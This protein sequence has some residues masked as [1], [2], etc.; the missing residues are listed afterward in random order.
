MLKIK[1]SHPDCMPK[2]GT[3]YSAGMDLRAFFGTNQNS[4]LRA[5]QPGKDLMI[6]T[7]V[8]MSIPEGWC[9]FVLP[10]SST[11]KLHCKLANTVGLI[12]SDYTGNIKLLVHNYGKEIVTLE[13][14]QRLCQIV[15]VPHYPTRNFEIVD[16]L[17]ETDRGTAGF[18]ST[19]AN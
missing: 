19:G 18:G 2:I 14:F 10:R 4:D 3:E 12:D 7:G 9:G 13:N 11:G 17:E 6:D 1:L 8:A 5:I 15:V 16:S